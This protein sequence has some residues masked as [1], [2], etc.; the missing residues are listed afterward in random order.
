MRIVWSG[1]ALADKDAI[2][3]YL[4]DRN[5]AYADKVEAKLDARTASLL[6]FPKLGRPV[7][8]SDLRELSIPESQHVVA[9]R[10]EGDVIRVMRVWSTKQDRGDVT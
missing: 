6:R 2:W 9:Y 1:S 5:V 3:L 10:I 8:G 7:P 4:A